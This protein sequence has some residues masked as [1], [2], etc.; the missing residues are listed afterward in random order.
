MVW[1]DP[2]WDKDYM[3]KGGIQWLKLAPKWHETNPYKKA[4]ARPGRKT[5]HKQEKVK[6]H[7]SQ[8]SKSNNTQR[9]PTVPSPPPYVPLYPSLD[10][11]LGSAVSGAQQAFDQQRK[12]VTRD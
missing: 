5:L 9:N 10:G 12:S 11:V 3:E 1:G 7:R 6:Q 8:A 4:D 2:E